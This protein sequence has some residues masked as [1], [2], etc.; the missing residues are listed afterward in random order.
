MQQ[1]PFKCPHCEAFFLDP[2]QRAVHERMCPHRMLLMYHQNHQK[3]TS[4]LS[5]DMML[6]PSTGGPMTSM[7]NFAPYRFAY[8]TNAHSS[9][10]SSFE[11]P[12]GALNVTNLN[13]SAAHA[14]A[15][16]HSYLNQ[17]N[18][19]HQF[20]IQDSHKGLSM[21]NPILHA[22]RYFPE[23]GYNC[24][25]GAR[26]DG[27]SWNN[28]L[29]S[30]LNRHSTSNNRY[31]GGSFYSGNRRNMD[32][33]DITHAS[34]RNYLLEG[35][36]QHM[37]NNPLAQPS[38][39]SRH[40]M[41]TLGNDHH[42]AMND[43]SK[44]KR[45]GHV[46]ID[47]ATQAKFARSEAHYGNSMY[48]CTQQDVNDT[49][50][51]NNG[52]L[53]HADTRFV[54]EKY[55]FAMDN[56]DKVGGVSTS[57]KNMVASE[58]EYLC[59]PEDQVYMTRFAYVLMRQMT[60]STVIDVDPL[61]QAMDPASGIA[62]RHCISDITGLFSP[63]SIRSNMSNTTKTT[64]NKLYN[65]VGHCQQCPSLV[66]NELNDLRKNHDTE[67]LSLPFG[68]QKTFI[69]RLWTRLRD[70]YKGLA[71]LT[72]PIR[73]YHELDDKNLSPIQ[74]FIRK[75]CIEIFT[76]THDDVLYPGRGKG[77]KKVA[78]Q[79][80]IRCSFCRVDSS[81]N[82]VRG[83]VYFPRSI[84]LMYS[85][86]MN[87]IQRHFFA[88]PFISCQVKEEYCTLKQENARSGTSKVYWTQSAANLGLVDTPQGIRYSPSAAVVVHNHLTLGEGRPL[89]P[90]KY[91]KDASGNTTVSAHSPL[92]TA[93]SIS[94]KV[95]C[96]DEDSDTDDK[97]Q[98]LN[99]KAAGD[100][101]TP[102]PDMAGVHDGVNEKVGASSSQKN[103]GVC[104]LEYI[105]FPK[106][107]ASMTRFNYFL[108]RQM[109]FCS[110]T[111]TDRLGKRK[112]LSVG[113]GG[114]ACR[115]CISDIGSGRFFPSSIDSLNDA[116]KHSLYTHILKCRKCPSTVK[117]ELN[118]LRKSHSKERAELPQG[119]HKTIIS[120]L[121]RRLHP[122]SKIS[123][124]PLSGSLGGEP[125][126]HVTPEGTRAQSRRGRCG[127]IG[128]QLQRYIVPPHSNASNS[129]TNVPA[130]HFTQWSIPTDGFHAFGDS[131][132]LRQQ[133]QSR[134][135]N[136]IES[137]VS[138]PPEEIRSTTT[139]GMYQNS[140][141]K[142]SHIY[143]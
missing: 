94:D 113:Y 53:D 13:R 68:S 124:Y 102:A 140:I 123:Q 6:L 110:F 98:C 99:P 74:C 54:Q 11:L 22:N 62:C 46:A 79:V 115:Y 130:S 20:N 1:T 5:S 92:K 141:E 125:Q 118:N 85:A 133:P 10:P 116:A 47:E 14:S 61:D 58:L 26:A 111:E 23:I 59:Q 55:T 60:F 114:I 101:L 135:S 91:E 95:C 42:E 36:H 33:Y 122:P 41:N 100:T 105:C 7:H 12:F 117:D 39:V 76:A 108:L 142:S 107:E 81:P 126:S 138:R 134:V 67:T 136:S 93:D 38:E 4:P 3:N 19:S 51:S 77:N 71:V 137:V 50:P 15:S 66:K 52:N 48:T 69:A 72:E 43:D 109:T 45:K 37:S 40:S 29:S 87:L 70:H 90:S 80:G 97:V 106:D 65:H 9:P 104:D 127:P 96:N 57:Q 112:D 16:A 21:S 17:Y 73:L 64:L 88:C 27:S 56:I 103:D 143:E 31:Q 86:S 32:R 63:P 49:T 30:T 132:L 89:S 24:L 18:T 128:A 75:K 25:D 44:H 34:P 28:S 35:Y 8:E 119:S 120:R 84:E 82:A 121:W 2:F 131:Q 139:D 78:G 129:A 83:S